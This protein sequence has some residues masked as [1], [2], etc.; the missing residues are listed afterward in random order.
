MKRY[1]FD[2]SQLNEKAF[3]IYSDSS[4]VFYQDHDGAFWVAENLK[5]ASVQEIGNIEK[6][7]D[8]LESF[9]DDFRI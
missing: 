3:A 4:F 1:E 6:V 2:K 8:F 7:N 5:T 9:E